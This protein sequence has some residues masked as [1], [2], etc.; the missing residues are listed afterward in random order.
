MIYFLTYSICSSSMPDKDLMSKF[1]SK[2]R[3][4]QIKR[5][6]VTTSIVTETV[7]PVEEVEIG[8][9]TEAIDDD[10]PKEVT[11]TTTSIVTET[12]H[13]VT[14]VTTVEHTEPSHDV[15]HKE[16]THTTTSIVTET[17]HPITEVRTVEHTE[18]T[19]DE[20]PKEI[21]YTTTSIVT[22][23][24]HPVTEVR[25]VEH[26][27]AMHEDKPKEITYTTTSVVTETVHPVTE[28]RTV[29]HTEATHEDKP[30]EFTYTTTS[31]VTETV[32]PV[33]EVRFVEHTEGKHDDVPTEITYTTRQTETTYTITSK[34]EP[35]VIT[36][37]TTILKDGSSTTVEE[38]IE[39]K[40]QIITSDT[41]GKFDVS[42]IR[43][44]TLGHFDVGDLDDVKKFVPK[45]LDLIEATEITKEQVKPVIDDILQ[46]GTIAAAA[47]SP[48]QDKDIKAITKEIVETEKRSYDAKV[49]HKEERRHSC[50]SP[51]ISLERI[52]ESEVET[53]DEP[54]KPAT[55]LT[56]ETHKV[57]EI[58]T[59]MK[60]SDSAMKQ[61]ADNIEIIIKQASEDIDV[62]SEEHPVDDEPQ[63]IAG[64]VS[65]D[66]IIEEAV[67][68]VEG[69]LDEKDI[70]QQEIDA[71]KEILYEETKKFVKDRP[72]LIKSLSRDSGE[73]VI[74][75]KKKHPRTFSVQSSPEEVEEQIYTDSES[76]KYYNKPH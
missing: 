32:H 11:Y 74:M 1:L 33:T 69:Y 19:H 46:K 41:S 66:S 15:K 23:T 55:T 43:T 50:I 67:N 38:H 48:V 31:V 51:A 20:K 71:K 12:V 49:P 16:I 39:T 58:K 5:E 30:K 21:S 8:E 62:S 24:V 54:Q 35:K 28:V 76:G 7:H 42:K 26:G 34:D 27:Q 52:A 3:E 73:I 72:G 4:E 47:R 10:K 37:V 18:A 40:K 9:H 44:D 17:V 57:A 53:E 14:E 60:K 22:E 65:V 45:D 61:M 36:E 64:R 59:E 6:I 56:V 2:E 25:F 13:P 68:T 29:E 70:A 75:P 63:D